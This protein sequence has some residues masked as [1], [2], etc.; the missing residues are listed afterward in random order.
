MKNTEYH[1]IPFITFLGNM[2]IFTRQY[3]VFNRSVMIHQ[4]VKLMINDAVSLMQNKNSEH[5]ILKICVYFEIP[6]SHLCHHFCRST[7]PSQTVMDTWLYFKMA[8]QTWKDP[9]F[10]EVWGSFPRRKKKK[11]SRNLKQISTQQPNLLD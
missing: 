5:I 9:Q 8:K 7:L 6:T 10:V 11:K 3:T 4:C 1:H 2:H